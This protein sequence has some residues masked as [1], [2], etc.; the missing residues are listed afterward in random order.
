MKHLT[1]VIL[2]L[3]HGNVIC[4][5]R[6]ASRDVGR[7]GSYGGGGGSYKSS[8]L[9][10]GLTKPTWDLAKL[11]KFEKHFYKEH[12]TTAARPVVSW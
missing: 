1:S 11:P 7:G 2:E 8:T 6:F 12:P 9:G 5:Y 4:G 10:A 3:S